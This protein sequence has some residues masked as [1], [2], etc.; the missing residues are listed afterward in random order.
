MDA[1]LILAIG[2]V[3]VVG[4]ILALR[5]HAFLALILG[6]YIVASLSSREAIIQFNLSKKAA[7]EAAAKAAQETPMQRIV[8]EF[9]ATAG[10]IGILIA[11][12]TVVG[13]CLLDSGGADRIVRTLLR[14]WGEKHAPA[15]LL[16]GGF[17]L[18][19][20]VFY[21][22]VFLLMIPLGKALGLRTKKDYLLY[23]LSMIAGGTM[24]HS[25]VPPT[26]GPLF[27]AAELKVNMGLMIAGGIVV[28][29]ICGAIGF[30]FA[31]WV[32]RRMEIPVRNAAEFQ[33]VAI[34][35][36]KDLP[37][38]WLAALPI[39]LPVALIT[40]GS[41]L[42]NRVWKILGDANVALAISAAIG[43]I[44]LFAQGRK[45]DEVMNI[46][47]GKALAEGGSIILITSAGGAFGAML[48][49]SGIGPRLQDLAATW[50]IGI[51]PLAWAIT[52]VVRIAQGSSTVSMITAVGVVGGM[53]DAATLGFHPLWLALAIGCGSKPIPWMNDSGFWVM[54]K[55]SG[56]TERECLMTIS[57]M[58]T[59]MGVIGLFVVMALAK[60]FPM[61]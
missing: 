8:R 45:G 17:L 31:H 41:V 18:G 14:W 59:L 47:V 51:L 29:A 39:A 36:D 23:V 1:L 26:P 28:S 9:G 40:M 37:P 13:K 10:R 35:P 42:E 11:L 55:M 4:G 49:Q 50:N 33:E 52:A 38:F 58:V 27:I 57:P 22:T 53:A 3:V 54:S 46:G 15:A 16:A 61:I 7:P 48:Q 56:M 34:R 43:L 30:A 24:T 44:T 12:A 19:I 32:N 5:L 21:D 2:M 25:L 60:L 20:P 6:A